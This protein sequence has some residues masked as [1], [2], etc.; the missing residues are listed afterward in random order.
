[1]RESEREE[2]ASYKNNKLH[3]AFAIIRRKIY[4]HTLA[5]TH[6]YEQVMFLCVYVRGKNCNKI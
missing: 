3:F 1:V 2:E 5:H 4:I 6:S